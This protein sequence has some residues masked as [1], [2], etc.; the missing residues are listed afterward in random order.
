MKT[1]PFTLRF[2]NVDSEKTA[3]LR[4]LAVYIWTVF[5]LYLTLLS[6]AEI[7]LVIYLYRKRTL[8]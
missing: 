8:C 7:W 3:I 4:Q 6:G 1:D 2:R 5:G